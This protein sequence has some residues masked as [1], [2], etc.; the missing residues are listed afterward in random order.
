MSDIINLLPDSVA[1][2]IAAGE[3]VQRPA[4][5][6]KELVENAIDA[7]ATLVKV[8]IKD[9]GRTLIQVIDNGCGMSDTDAR[10]AFER[11]ATSKI[12][13]AEDIFAIRTM[14]F[15][16]EALA[17]I[18]AVAQVE[19]KSK[20]HDNDIGTSVSISGS[21]L[22]SQECVHCANGS[23]FLVKNLFFNIPARRKFLKA[24]TTEFR[25]I[26]ECFQ[27]IVLTYPEVAFV[28]Q[29]NDKEVY[30]L[31]KERIKQRIVRIF[32]AKYGNLI[33]VEVETSLATITGFI[34]KPEHAK[35]TGYEQFFFVNK[36]YMKHLPFHRRVQKAYEG[37]IQDSA[38]P[39][40][41]L[42]FE[43]DPAEIDV[44]IHPTKTEIKFTSEWDIA[45]ILEAGLREA[46]GKFNLV[47]S[48]D[49]NDDTDYN[50]MFAPIEGEATAPTIDI[51]ENFNPFTANAMPSY[52]Q[53]E[54]TSVDREQRQVH[55]PDFFP[56]GTPSQ[57]RSSNN[58]WSQQRIMSRGFSSNEN[59]T[60]QSS[61]HRE[62]VQKSM[63]M[64][65]GSSRFIQIKARYIAM[66]VKSGL[67]I[68]DQH[69]AHERILYEQYLE[70]ATA[71]RPT[72]NLLYPESV[73][74][75]PHEYSAMCEFLPMLQNIGFDIEPFGEETFVVRGVPAGGE[76]SDTSGLLHTMLANYLETGD[77]P[78]GDL[79]HK[80]A[81]SLAQ[82]GAISYG[83]VLSAQEMQKITDDLFST[84]SPNISPT[85]KKLI[86]ILDTEE[87]LNKFQ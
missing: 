48:L 25:F 75:T 35:K 10:M 46:L 79:R 66:P 22:L 9:A 23:N 80:V 63:E 73:R 53:A 85:G 47:P 71:R 2:Q 44:N 82:A 69:R 3:V 52:R 12:S 62:P 36:R 65:G 29:H 57:P 11:H 64:Q 68:I 56:S 31:P 45:Q 14:G 70:A 41:F 74:C 86:T 61:L 33:P 37:L 67:M 4:S 27:R 30:N 55:I 49:F 58:N 32:G 60:I 77:A 78:D 76:D 28:L 13:S 18:A 17:S 87:L 72:Q 59:T 1:N 83:T 42:Y 81:C 43:I 26:I 8:N 21:E 84:K 38:N 34:G 15:R 19:L 54:R 20:K 39:A 16:G 5:V 50:D 7:G 40:Y 24:N 51:D 6:V